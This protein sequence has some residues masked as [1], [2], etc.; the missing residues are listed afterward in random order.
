MRYLRFFSCLLL[1]VGLLCGCIGLPSTSLPATPGA[2]SV[3]V[4]TTGS[5]A[6]RAIQTAVN[7]TATLSILGGL[8]CLAFGGLAIYGGQLLPGVKL[9]IAGLLLPI[10]GIWW[11]YHWLLVTIIV[12]IGTAL[13][14]L[15]THYALVRPALLSVEAWAKTVETRLVS[16][17]APH[18]ASPGPVPATAHE[19]TSFEVVKPAI[20]AA[21]VLT[22][23]HKA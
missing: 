11:A 22:A 13:I 18:T 19:V 14:W 9:V 23:I 5:P 20:S 21:S 10:F 17:A 4:A 12:L 8:A 3:K 2:P 7:Y 1:T 6:K 15:T 16:S